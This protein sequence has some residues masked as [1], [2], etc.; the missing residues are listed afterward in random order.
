V[1]GNGEHPRIRRLRERRETHRR[2][3]RAVRLAVSLGGFAMVLGGLALLVLPGPGVPLLL[4][5]LALLALEFRWAEVTLSRALD[6]AE[7]GARGARA[8]SRRRKMALAALAAAGAG[9]AGTALTLW[10]VPG[11]PV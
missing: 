7:R 10:G 2:R 3:P 8:L 1:S 11:L 9:G 6:Q 5:G 4:A